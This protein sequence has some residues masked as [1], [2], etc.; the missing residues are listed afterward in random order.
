MRL[1][2][3]LLLS[4]IFSLIV[5]SSMKHAV[6]K[7]VGEYRYY[8]YCRFCFSKDIQIILDLGYMPLAGGFLKKLSKKTLEKEHYYP[9]ELMVC[10]NCF[11]VQTNA[12]IPADILFKEYFYFSSKIQTLVNHFQQ[13]AKNIPSMFSD[14]KK[15]FVVEIG[16]NDGSFIRAVQ[17][18]GYDALGIDPATNVAA[19]L[20]KKGIPIINDYFSAKLAQKIVKKYGKADAIY[21]FNTLAHI[22]DMHDVFSGIVTVLK[23]DGYMIFETHYLG[24][25]LTQMQYDMMYHEHQYYYSL[26]AIEKFLALHQMHVFNVDIVPTHGGSIRFSVQKNTGKRK[27]SETVKKLER[28]EKKQKIDTLKPY[29]QFAK[30]V[31]KTKKDLLALLTKLK[32]KKYTIAGYGASGRGTILSNYCGLDKKFLDYIVDDAP[33]KIGN[34]MPGT[35]LPIYSSKKLADKNPPDYV[36]L[37]AWAFVDEI[38]KRHRKYVENGGKFILPL[39]TVTILDKNS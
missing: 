25:L 8:D 23:D 37:F 26:F 22:E 36:L 35:H 39:P 18:I 16:C 19:P 9:L 29:T 38:K 20:V 34:Y 7:N 4:P 10:Q 30:E 17:E 6:T 13:I 1:Y 32:Q 24:D 28:K 27:I 14:T 2:Q 12:V 15:K 31:I 21:S 5:L 11:L 33:A 3:F